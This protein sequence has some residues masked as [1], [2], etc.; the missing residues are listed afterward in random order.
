[1]LEPGGMILFDDASW[2]AEKNLSARY[3]TVYPTM[4]KEESEI[5]AV[6]FVCDNL[7]KRYNYTE[8]ETTIFDWRLFVK[9][10]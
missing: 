3:S 7:V 4:S 10:K 9:N 8:S 2:Y 6:N 5:P 1:L